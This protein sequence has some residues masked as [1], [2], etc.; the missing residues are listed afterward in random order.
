MGALTLE[1][2]LDENF[3]RQV[4]SYIETEGHYGEHVVDVLGPGAGDATDIAP[5]A[6]SNDMI[7]LTKDT[8]FLEMDENDHAGVLFLVD[9]RRSAYEIASAVITIA[10]VFPDRD[11]LRSIEYV[12]SWL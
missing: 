2:L 11:H 5:Y 4:I 7:V 6:R 9:H 12:D 3:D 10:E 8:D 1:V